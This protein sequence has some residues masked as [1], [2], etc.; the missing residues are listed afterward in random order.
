MNDD[1]GRRTV[2]ARGGDG[3]AGEG[4]SRPG[5]G[6]EAGGRSGA[7]SKGGDGSGVPNAPPPED[8]GTPPGRRRDGF[9]ARVARDFRRLRD[10]KGRSFWMALLDA[11]LFD[12]GFQALFCYRCGSALRRAGVPVLP[13]VLRR[14]A[15]GA[16]AVDLLPGADLGGGCIVAHGVGLVVGGQTVV[17]EDCTLLHGVTLGEVRFDE[18][19]CPRLGDRVTVGVGA[20][21]LGGVTVGDDALVGAGAVV[22]EDVP[23][24][25]RVAGVPARVIGWQ[26]GYG[27]DGGGAPLRDGGAAGGPPPASPSPGAGGPELPDPH[28]P[29]SSEPPPSPEDP[30]DAP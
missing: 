25:A 17:G 19:A 15:I 30:E 27:P 22:R 12:A 14:W 10:V 26:P 8:D 28:D 5:D 1:E 20:V 11:A 7:G 9:G 13:A 16:C 6:S 29:A 18:M 2:T 24:G 3:G 23:P 4:G 21:I